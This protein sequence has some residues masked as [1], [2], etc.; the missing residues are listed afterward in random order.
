MF[1]YADFVPRQLTTAGG[2][3]GKA[4][5]YESFHGAVQA[6]TQWVTA[7]GIQVINV[8]TV[9][10]LD[11]GTLESGGTASSQF[12]LSDPYPLRQF[13]RVWYYN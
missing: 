3:F 5:T 8:E 9:L 6:A 10:M 13:V 1:T 11:N 2:L 12:Y 4:A 7:N